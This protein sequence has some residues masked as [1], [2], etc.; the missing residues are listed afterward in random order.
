MKQITFEDTDEGRRFFKLSMFAAYNREYRFQ[1]EEE[2]RNHGK[3][4]DAVEDVTDVDEN[5]EGLRVLRAGPQAI[6]LDDAWL[7]LWIR[8]GS[9]PNMHWAAGGALGKTTRD[10][11]KMLDFL[12]AA[13]NYVIPKKEPATT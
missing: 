13:K 11:I 1:S 12:K 9:P 2:M 7:Q 3:L 8:M 5:N 4:L 6:L 10:A